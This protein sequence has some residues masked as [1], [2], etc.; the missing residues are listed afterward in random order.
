[1][2]RRIAG[3]EQQHTTF[4]HA[5]N[6]KELEY[7]VVQTTRPKP[8]LAVLL[9][10]PMFLLYGVMGTGGGYSTLQEWRAVSPALRSFALLWLI[11]GTAMLLASVG[12]LGSLGRHSPSLRLGGISAALF[13]MLRA[14]GSFTEIVPCSGPA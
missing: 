10:V 12:V 4:W 9:F 1:M 2:R 6:C 7:Y 5:P 11:T 3:Q 14:G 8:R 13:G